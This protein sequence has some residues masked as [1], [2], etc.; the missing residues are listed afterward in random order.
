MKRIRIVALVLVVVLVVAVLMAK[1]ML[2]GVAQQTVAVDGSAPGATVVAAAGATPVTM[3]RAAST[4]GSGPTSA[5][6]AP[7][8]APTVAAEAGTLSPEDQFKAALSARKPTLALFHSLTCVPCKAM[9]AAVEEVRSEYEGQVTFVDVDVYDTANT[10][11]CRSARIQMIPTTVLV[12]AKGEE[13][14]RVGAVETNQLRDILNQ[15]LT[16]T[17]SS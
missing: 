8:T 7:D 16:A 1:T 6:A 12:N 4:P 14:K 5:V 17:Q 9:A 15:L 10:S 13:S 3:D 11:F 2:G